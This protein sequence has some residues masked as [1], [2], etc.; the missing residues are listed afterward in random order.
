M[1]I[2]LLSLFLLIGLS[3]VNAQNV[4]IP[5]LNFKKYLVENTSINT[6]GDTEIQVSEAEAFTGTID[7]SYKGSIFTL[8]GI[9]AFKNIK[10]LISNHTQLTVLDISKNTA[11]TTLYC[12][13]NQL[14]SLDVSKNTDLTILYCGGNKLT[15]LDVSKN[16]ALIVLACESTQLKTLD[17]SKNTLLKT[18]SCEANQLKTLDVSKNIALE[19]LTC[20]G[21]ELEFLDVSKNTA[22][23]VL[24]CEVNQLTVLDISKNT[25][26]QLLYCGF[27]RL[28]SLDVSKNTS[29]IRLW[30]NNNLFTSFNIK[31]GKNY[32]MSNATGT[33]AMRAYNNPNLKCIQVDNVANSYAN[34]NWYKDSIASYNIDCNSVLSV[35]NISKQLITLSTNPVKDIINF[36]DEV[37][38]IK[39]I[40]ISGKI[41]KQFPAPV[42]SLNVSSLSKGNYI[43][44][45]TSKSGEVLNKKFI[46]Q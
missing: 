27:N 20:D 2:L 12:V 34:I 9:Q 32:L 36:S 39:I 21:T 17:V 22:L 11:L 29:L 14:T 6:N 7:C 13:G 4:D 23:T 8:E 25:N 44:N 5:D 28:G 18:L 30:C 40:D 38:N 35:S 1:K 24:S 41:V 43:I 3:S 26:L 10:G 42:K 15:S 19:I 31:N 37:S 16:L 33:P 45:V 46:K